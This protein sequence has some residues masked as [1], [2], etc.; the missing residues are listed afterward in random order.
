MISAINL[1]YCRFNTKKLFELITVVLYK[2][3]FQKF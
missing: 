2:D 1:I 3:L